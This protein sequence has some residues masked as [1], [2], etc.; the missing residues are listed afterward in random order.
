V[1]FFLAVF[2]L[3]ILARA[4]VAASV[5]SLVDQLYY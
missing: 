2:C 1:A 4:I 5:P 3:L